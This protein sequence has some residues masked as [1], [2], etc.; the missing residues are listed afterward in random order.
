LATPPA[1]QPEVG[2]NKAAPHS[3]A[4]KAQPPVPP[5]SP[6]PVKPPQSGPN[7]GTDPHGGVSPC[8]SQDH[9]HWTEKVSA[10]VAVAAL[11]VAVSS[12]LV[13]WYQWDAMNNQVRVM[14][15]A[16]AETA[17]A[18]RLAERA[19]LTI[20]TVEFTKDKMGLPMAATVILEN[21]GK[22]PA[23]RVLFTGVPLAY[24]KGVLPPCLPVGLGVQGAIGPSVKKTLNLTFPPEMIQDLRTT[25][26]TAIV[27]GEFQY[28]DI[29]GDTV[30][31]TS[32]CYAYDP[33]KKLQA[34]CSG[35]DKNQLD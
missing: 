17:R 28:L 25:K 27:C 15:E 19:W 5:Q 32:F 21:T 6:R 30:R 10:L 20:K 31:H 26:A 16:N 1:E 29:F 18:N 2:G 22:T 23:R 34:P 3:A 14:Q 4:E 35:A 8:K 33:I 7:P 24:N 9:P 12:F 13:A 11:L